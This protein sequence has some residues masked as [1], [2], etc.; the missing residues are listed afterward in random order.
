MAQGMKAVYKAM[1]KAKLSHIEAKE[2]RKSVILS[3][4]VDTWEEKI[5]A[6]YLATHKGYKGVVNDIEVENINPCS[7]DLPKQKDD[8]LQDKRFDV[9]IIGGGVI[10]CSLLRELSRYKIKTILIDKEEDVAKHAS[11]RNDGM[12]HPGFAAS[13]GSKKAHYN[14]RGNRAYTKVCKELGIEF[15]R[16]GSLIIFTHPLSKLITPILIHRAKKNNV[17]GYKYISRAKLRQIEPN[18]AT[19]Q[20]GAFFLPSAGVLSPYRL[21]IAFAENALKNGADIS[22][23]TAVTGFDMDDN[24]ISRVKTNRGSFYA[25]V[26]VNASGIWADVVAGYADDRFFSLHPRKGVDAILDI[27]TGKYQTR[28]G[29]LVKFSQMKS[30][31]KGGGIVPAIEGNLLIGP[32]AEEVPY[33]EDYSTDHKSMTRL[34]QIMKAN[35]KIKRS[36]IITYFAG[37]R[38]CTYEEDFIIEPSE[39]VSNFVHVAGIQ[40][41]GLASAPAIAEDASKMCIDMLKRIKDVMPNEHFDPYRKTSPELNLLSLEDR[42]KLIKDNPSYGRIVCRCEAVSEGEIKDALGSIMPANTLDGVK[43]RTRAGAGRCHGGFCTP[44]VM[45]IMSDEMNTKLTEI[46]KKGY[47][48]QMLFSETKGAIDY[49]N[50]KVKTKESEG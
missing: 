1:R 13:P 49:S 32:T 35:I 5:K 2:W 34:Q 23:N 14:V 24:R 16:V 22:L 3:G 43:R 25:D 30:K 37:T 36:D 39:Y 20:H 45:E 10:G 6:G 11:S 42:A 8:T 21:T 33:R 9:A 26:V 27:K 40:S 47:G 29:A 41:P 7:I 44:R 50:K 46:N 19:Q 4:R 18:I 15:K 17:D 31:T 28:I 48:S 38:A 12:I